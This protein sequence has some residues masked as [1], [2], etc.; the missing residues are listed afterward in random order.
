MDREAIGAIIASPEGTRILVA[1]AAGTPYKQL[2][3]TMA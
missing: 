2:L 1:G 3:S